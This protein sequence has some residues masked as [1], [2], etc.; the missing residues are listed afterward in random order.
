MKRKEQNRSFSNFLETI[1]LESVI[2]ITLK[3]KFLSVCTASHSGSQ[4]SIFFT[5]TAM[6]T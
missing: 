2:K 3:D 1:I 6:R 5:F 4:C